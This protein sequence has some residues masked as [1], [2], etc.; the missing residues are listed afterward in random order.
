MRAIGNTVASAVAGMVIA[1]MTIGFHGVELPSENGLRAVLAIGVAAAAASLAIAALIPR[2]WAAS[3]TP[4]PRS[5][6]ETAVG[7]SSPDGA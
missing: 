5:V 2:S 6:V 7:G 1:H 3:A 4:T